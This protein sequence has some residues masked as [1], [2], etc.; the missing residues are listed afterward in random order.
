[1]YVALVVPTAHGVDNTCYYKVVDTAQVTVT[2]EV[3]NSDGTTTQIVIGSTT[4]VYYTVECDGA[5]GEYTGSDDTTWRIPLKPRITIDHI[6]TADPF[7]P[8]LMVEVASDPEDPAVSI[9]VTIGSSLVANLPVVRDGAYQ[10]PLPSID[11]YRAGTHSISAKACTQNGLCGSASASM[12]RTT[13]SALSVSET[14]GGFYISGDEPFQVQYGHQF[15][16]A[17]M[18]TSFT[19]TEFGLTSRRQFRGG[20]IKTQTSVGSL[21]GAFKGKFYYTGTAKSTL[22]TLANCPSV[23]TCY[24]FCMHRCLDPRLFG[25]SVTVED[26]VYDMILPDFTRIMITSNGRLRHVVP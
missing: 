24:G 20:L 15:N 9:G 17:Y 16:Q 11:D 22:Y 12:T 26:E 19:A 14:I 25:R 2:G 3:R 18:M 6:N 7:A 10:V 21:A 23:P 8:K 13:P 4:Y 1:M 5:T